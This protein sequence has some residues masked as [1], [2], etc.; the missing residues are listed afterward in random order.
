MTPTRTR[1]QGSFGAC[2]YRRVI[3]CP[4]HQAT[5]LLMALRQRRIPY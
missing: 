4:R 5:P 2:D 3:G 1:T